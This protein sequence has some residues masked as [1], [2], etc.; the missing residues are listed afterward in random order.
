MARVQATRG[1]GSRRLVAGSR[2]AW[3][4]DPDTDCARSSTRESQPIARH[5]LSLINR[6]FV[7]L[8]L[9]GASTA[10]DDELLSSL[11]RESPFA[12]TGRSPQLG[13]KFARSILRHLTSQGHEGTVSFAA[14]NAE[15][16]LMLAGID[17]VPRAGR[18]DP[19]SV[20][21]FRMISCLPTSRPSSSLFTPARWP[22]RLA[23]SCART[24]HLVFVHCVVVAPYVHRSPAGEDFRLRYVDS[25]KCREYSH[26]PPLSAGAVYGRSGSWVWSVPSA[27]A[28]YF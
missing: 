23:R 9:Y 20:P 26:A 21:V 2:S 25:Q 8:Y 4:R 12:V 15:D 7:P 10:A 19:V 17:T 3:A 11:P 6:S 28:Y 14:R 18:G 1:A 5:L 27:S 24:L 16:V 13:G 22:V